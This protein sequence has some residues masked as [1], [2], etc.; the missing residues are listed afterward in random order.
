MEPHRVV[1]LTLDARGDSVIG[2]E[3][4]ER[5]H[6]AHAEPTLGVVVGRDFYYVANSQWELFGETGEVAR[7]DELALPAILRLRL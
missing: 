1:R 4:L 6:P 3:V 7:P 2:L 5:L